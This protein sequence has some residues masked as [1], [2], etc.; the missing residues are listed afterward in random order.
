MA[1]AGEMPL[2]SRGASAPSASLPKHLMRGMLMFIMCLLPRA[3]SG[4]RNPPGRDTNSGGE[5]WLWG[6]Q[7]SMVPEEM[8]DYGT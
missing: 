7:H 4:L 5:P 6:Q 1:F 3:K 8:V 2:Q